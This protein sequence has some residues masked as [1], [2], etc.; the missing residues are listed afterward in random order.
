[1]C[2]YID[3]KLKQRKASGPSSFRHS[4]KQIAQK[5]TSDP[6]RM[7]PTRLDEWRSLC[8]RR[9]AV[10]GDGAAGEVA[11]AFGKARQR[12]DRVRHPG[13]GDGVGAAVDAVRTV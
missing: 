4:V 13:V 2:R 5:S 3:V 9:A 8:E 10:S 1:M 6:R 12:P 11:R 7:S